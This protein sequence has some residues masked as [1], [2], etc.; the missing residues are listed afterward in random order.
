MKNILKI[1][2]FKSG[3][4]TGTFIVAFIV[5]ASLLV[6]SPACA[7]P[8]QRPN[9]VGLTLVAYEDTVRRD[10]SGTGNRPM[11]AAIWYP[12]AAGAHEAEWKIGIFN[13]GLN[14]QGAPLTAS[15]AKLPLVVLSH[16]TGGG[17][18]AISWLAETLAS[19]GY[20]VAAVNHHGNTA[21]EPSYRLEGFVIWWERPK[22]MSVLIDKLLADPRF[23]PR[24]D[25]TRIGVAGFSLG[26]YTALATVGARLNLAQ[27]KGFCTAKPADPNCNLPPEIQSTAAD[28]QRLLDQNERVKQAVAHSHESFRD[29]RVKAAFA[30]APVL[31]PA[32]TADSLAEIQTPVRIVV[33]SKDD[34]ALPDIN[35]KPVAAA[36]PKAE[37]EV[38]PDVAHYTFLATCNFA[39]LF[40]ARRICVD[41][42]GVDRD[43]IHRRVSAE[44]VEFFNR[45]LQTTIIRTGV[46]Q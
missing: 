10:W 1:S 44:A 21:S 9:P 41:P 19:N 43:A 15:P 26:G 11:A 20:L 42:D 32:L 29:T 28:A 35:A 4:E 30:I 18:A 5:F 45:V 39:G 46:R 33:G 40:A 24:I 12:A 25:P 14:A 31:G 17:V 37:L 27:W 7:G 8:T 6:I 13:A 22:D 2:L 23:G 34:Q 38:L 3:I 36:I 16:G